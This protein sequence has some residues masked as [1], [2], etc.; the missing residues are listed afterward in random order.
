MPHLQPLIKTHIRGISTC[1]DRVY[2]TKA[3]DAGDS[4]R[5]LA[6][7]WHHVCALTQLLAC[8]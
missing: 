3:D 4:D 7:Q 2:W 8:P 5:Y 6:Q 1:E